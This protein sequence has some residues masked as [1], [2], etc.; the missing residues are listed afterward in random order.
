MKPESVIVASFVGSALVVIIADASTGSLPS[1]RQALA[2]TLAFGLTAGIATFAPGPAAGLAVLI[3]AGV[4]L[5]Y[6]APFFGGVSNVATAKGA[7]TQAPKGVDAPPRTDIGAGTTTGAGPVPAQGAVGQLFASLKGVTV[8]RVDY[9]LD[10]AYAGATPAYA[11]APGVV[12]NISSGW[13]HT[14]DA[15]Q[16][17]TAIYIKLDTPIDGYP[18]MYY[19]EGTPAAGIKQGQQIRAGQEV[20]LNPGEIGLIPSPGTPTLYQTPQPSGVKTKAYLQ[21]IGAIP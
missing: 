14:A 13:G 2:G 8:G 10:F 18:Y 1:G 4:V 5:N 16:T 6:A 20:M 15:Y 3:A 7:L 21:S 12:A 19:A 17:G 9:G 11:I